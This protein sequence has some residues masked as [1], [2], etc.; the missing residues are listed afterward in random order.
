MNLSKAIEQY[1]ATKQMLGLSF[2]QG[3]KILQS[4]QSHTGD[5]PVRTISRWHVL[6]FSRPFNTFGCDLAAEI[7]AI[8]S[9]F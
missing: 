6:G 7:Q 1:G 8:K 2:T 4:F 9:I 5:R 3:M